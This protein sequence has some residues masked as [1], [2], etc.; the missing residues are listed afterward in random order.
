[1]AIKWHEG[2]KDQLVAADTVKP[3]PENANSADVDVIVE[4]IRRNGVYRPLIVQK[5]SRYI[6][7]GHGTYAALMELQQDDAHPQV[8]VSL[9][10]C[11]EATA[12]RIVAVDNRSAARARM[13][14]GLL[15]QLLTALDG[16]LIG[17][18]FDDDDL[19][20]LEVDVNAPFQPI[21]DDDDSLDSVDAKPCPKCGYDIANDPEALRSR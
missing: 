11:D 1:M 15:L 19:A 6:L 13:D 14:D 8:P 7:A 10:Q 3:H 21:D 4:S 2:V 16:D 17:T 9:V 5:R 18:G 20:R 12:R